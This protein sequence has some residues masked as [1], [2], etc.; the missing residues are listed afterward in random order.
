LSLLRREQT[1]PKGIKV[2][3]LQAAWNEQYLTKILFSSH[4][5]APATYAA[6]LAY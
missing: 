6:D 2:K 5:F 4:A 1:S 3:R